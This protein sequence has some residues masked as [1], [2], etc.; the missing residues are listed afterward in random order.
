MKKLR[1]FLWLAVALC[2]AAIFMFSGESASASTGT[3]DG[4][5][6]R[7]LSLVSDSFRNMSD[8]GQER[9]I[10]GLSHFVRKT[11]HFCVYF[12]LGFLVSLVLSTYFNSRRK[13]II[14]STLLCAVY[15]AS[16]ELHQYF[17]P[18]RA[19][20][21]RDVLLDT[22]GS[23]CGIIVIILIIS[24]VRKRKINPKTV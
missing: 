7:A 14:F 20:M 19:C 11:A 1:F 22:T 13:N 18:G 8:D 16:D 6:R 15:A 3:S 24:A 4:F 9:I 21:L 12:S 2:A 5:T 23:L 17:V 10:R